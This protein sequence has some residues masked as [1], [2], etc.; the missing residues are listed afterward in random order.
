MSAHAR[1]NTHQNNDRFCLQAQNTR[2]GP[3]QGGEPHKR[4]RTNE[5]AQSEHRARRTERTKR[6]DVA[7]RGRGSILLE[8]EREN[9]RCRG[10][11]IYTTTELHPPSNRDERNCAEHPNETPRGVVAR[12]RAY[13][14]QC[15]ETRC[16]AFHRIALHQARKNNSRDG[17]TNNPGCGPGKNENT[18]TT[19]RPSE[20]VSVPETNE[21]RLYGTSRSIAARIEEADERKHQC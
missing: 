17:T 13:Q 21:R 10:G 6:N 1:D 2:T 14:T 7:I 8:R 5:T 12:L 9:C 19:H 11:S 18:A 4:N 3:E 20:C 15:N 16:D